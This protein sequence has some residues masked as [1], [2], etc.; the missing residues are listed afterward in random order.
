MPDSPTELWRRASR[1]FDRVAAAEGVERERLLAELAAD[2]PAV[3][4]EVVALLAAD[5]G[6]SRFLD[7]VAT[8]GEEPSPVGQRIG[9]WRIVAPLGRGG[10]GEVFVA[11]R[12][13]GA[14]RKRAALKRLR[15][16]LDT[17]ALVR[18]FLRE[19][20]ILATLDHPGIARLLDGGVAQ[21]GRPFFVLELVD[22][23]PIT[24]WADARQ[25]DAPARLRL[26]LDVCAAV[27]AA[28]RRL[29]VHRDL[30]PSNVLVDREGR[31]RLLDF[32]VAKLLDPDE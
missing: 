1:A 7:A 5:P 23:E 6:T 13:D 22:G 16:G 32:G 12:A 24:T 18:R 30:K 3:H 31:V 10:M 20:Q 9:D 28:H 19:R 4:A 2:D 11:E 26:F 25:L 17:E 27:E 29:V 14:Y 21:D 15:R 8:A